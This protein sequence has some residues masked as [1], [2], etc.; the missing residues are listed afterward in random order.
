MFRDRKCIPFAE[1]TKVND[2]L[3]LVEGLPYA[4]VRC[5]YC[6]SNKFDA[7]E[8]LTTGCLEFICKRCKSVMI[9]KNRPADWDVL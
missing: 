3:T 4:P 2:L 9:S 8:N 6:I 7:Y 1:V 5:H